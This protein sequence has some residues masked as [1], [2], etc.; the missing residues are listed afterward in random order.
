MDKSFFISLEQLIASSQ[1]DELV[2]AILTNFETSFLGEVKNNVPLLSS[3]YNKATKDRALNLVDYKEYSQ[4]Q[5]RITNAILLLLDELRKKWEEKQ[6]T[7]TA[8]TPPPVAPAD[9]GLSRVVGADGKDESSR[10]I[11]WL[12]QSLRA[13]QNVCHILL[14]SGGMGTGVYLGKRYLLTNHFIL[15]SPKV[16]TDAIVRFFYDGTEGASG[17]AM[18]SVRLSENSF[19]TD[20][21]IGV[22]IVELADDDD[23]QLINAIPDLLIAGSPAQP[24]ELV[25]LIHHPLGGTKKIDVLAEILEVKTEQVVYR[26]ATHPGSS[27]GAVLNAGNELLGIHTGRLANGV[28]YFTPVSN[29]IKLLKDREIVR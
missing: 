18:L 6:R 29:F 25:S 19:F 9:T 5:A 2:S 13:A 7:Q 12:Q 15:P 21:K 20:D 3:Q 24:G 22:T 27:G 8:D 16:A 10:P 1:I 11:T 26:A 17:Q 23:I 4:D 28:Q 14:P